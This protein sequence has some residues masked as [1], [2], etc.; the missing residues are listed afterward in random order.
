MDLFS[1][2]L[3]SSL[4]HPRSMNLIFPSGFFFG[5]ILASNPLIWHKK[6]RAALLIFLRPLYTN[7]NMSLLHLPRLR[8]PILSTLI[9]FVLLLSTGCSF[10]ARRA[11]PESANRLPFIPATIVP[12]PVPP[13]ATP[14][15]NAR[16][17]STVECTDML[18]YKSDISIPDGTVVDPG[19][20]LDKRWEVENSGTCN[21]GEGYHLKLVNGDPM[22]VDQEQT[23]FPA[24]AGT[25]PVIRIVFTAPSKPGTYRSAWQAYNP[26]GQPFGDPFFIQVVVKSN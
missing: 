16:I 4:N 14:L 12:S 11:D 19:A 20:T 6:N 5:L 2:Q 18:V 3:Q 10:Q 21:W 22:G 7:M 9:S 24:R 25:R 8:K 17:T 15:P 23:L 13:T 26:K 1:L